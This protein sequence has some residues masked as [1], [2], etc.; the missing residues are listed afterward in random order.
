MNKELKPVQTPGARCRLYRKRANM[1]QAELAERLYCSVDLISA[2]ERG[3]RTL[4]NENA[5]AMSAI[6]GVRKECLLCFDDCE[7]ELEKAAVPFAKG[8]V[9]HQMEKEAFFLYAMLYD[10]RDV[11]CDDSKSANISRDEFLGMNEKEQDAIMSECSDNPDLFYY[12]FQNVNGVEVGRC[13]E[14]EFKAIV[15]ELSEFAE[16]KIKRICERT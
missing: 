9:S 5:A 1:T 6:F 12:S 8:V 16:F 7:T 10:Y 11:W 14:S 15:K 3:S 13:S 4:T 2:I